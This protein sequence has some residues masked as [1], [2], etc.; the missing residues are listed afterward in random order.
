MDELVARVLGV[1]VQIKINLENKG[2]GVFA[3]EVSTGPRSSRPT[4]LDADA[5]GD[6]QCDGGDGLGSG[7]S[8]IDADETDLAMPIS[9]RDGRASVLSHEARPPSG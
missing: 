2:V 5:D 9:G 3:N 8:D 4:T 1:G 7:D 6:E